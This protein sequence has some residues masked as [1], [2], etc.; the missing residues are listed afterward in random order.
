MLR[1]IDKGGGGN[2]QQYGGGEGGWLFHML[3]VW[4]LYGQLI[5][6]IIFVVVLLNIFEFIIARQMTIAYQRG[7]LANVWQIMKKLDK[8]EEEE[9]EVEEE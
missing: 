7:G 1:I 4:Y 2:S 3:K 6:W 9:E 5:E 8:D